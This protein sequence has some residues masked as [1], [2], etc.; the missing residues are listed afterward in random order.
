MVWDIFSNQTVDLHPVEDDASVK[1]YLQWSLFH[2]ILEI[3]LC[4]KKIPDIFSLEPSTCGD[5][6]LF[7][8]HHLKLRKCHVSESWGVLD[9]PPSWSRGRG[10]MGFMRWP[11]CGGH[12]GCED[13]GWLGRVVGFKVNIFGDIPKYAKIC[14]GYIYILHIS[15]YMYL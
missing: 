2:S 11:A 1:S 12:F 3:L 7:L 5:L 6:L 8:G 10:L 13:S 4:K 15:I 14:Q 9:L